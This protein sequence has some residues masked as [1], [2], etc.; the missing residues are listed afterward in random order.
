LAYKNARRLM[1]LRVSLAAVALLGF[2]AKRGNHG[3]A[4]AWVADSAGGAMYEIFR[5]LVLALMLPRWPEARIAIVFLIATCALEFLQLWHPPPLECLRS[6]SL[7]HAILGS[8]F[9]WLDFPYYFA[10]SAAGWLWLRA[11]TRWR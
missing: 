9:D 5:C 8:H 6:F 10:G 1:P 2:Y 3:L 7:G 4:A 11:L